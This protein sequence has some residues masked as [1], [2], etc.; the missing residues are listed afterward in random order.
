MFLLNPQGAVFAAVYDYDIADDD[1]VSFIEGDRVIN[2][3]LI[4]DGWMIGTVSRTGKR[5]MVP[6]N[7]FEEMK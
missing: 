3:T 5:G 2:A 7:Y 4:D 6:T 1:E